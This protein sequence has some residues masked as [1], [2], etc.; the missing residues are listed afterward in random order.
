V[1]AKAAKINSEIGAEAFIKMPAQYITVPNL[2][3]SGLSLPISK[4]EGMF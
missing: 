1:S 4:T 2:M 3:P